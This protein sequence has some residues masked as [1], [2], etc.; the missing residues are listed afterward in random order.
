MW[1]AGTH[2]VGQKL[3]TS[4]NMAGV[5]LTLKFEVASFTGFN[6][7]VD[8]HNCSIPT[9][10]GKGLTDVHNNVDPDPTAIFVHQT[11]GEHTAHLMTSFDH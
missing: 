3:W 9:V 1:W 4:G 10:R 8:A 2:R 5:K 7:M 6:D 11:Y